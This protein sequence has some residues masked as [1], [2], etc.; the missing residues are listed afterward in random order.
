MLEKIVRGDLFVGICHHLRSKL[1]RPTTC[2][3]S[4]SSIT[5]QSSESVATSQSQKT[6]EDQEI[7]PLRPSDA[8]YEAQS[9]ADRIRLDEVIQKVAELGYT[10]RRLPQSAFRERDWTSMMRCKTDWCIKNHLGFVRARLKDG[11]SDRRLKE[12]KKSPAALEKKR[13]IAED[14]TEKFARGEMVYSLSKNN[15]LLRSTR[16]RMKREFYLRQASMMRL[17]ET[18]TALVDCGFLPLQSDKEVN[19][20]ASQIQHLLTDNLRSIEPWNIGLVNLDPQAPRMKEYI[21]MFLWPYM[22]GSA[23]ESEVEVDRSAVDPRIDPLISHKSYV[24]LFDRD[25]LVYLSPDAEEEL[26]TIDNDDIY[27][28]GAIVDVDW[29]NRPGVMKKKASWHKA[30]EDGVRCV[31]LPLDKYIKS[32]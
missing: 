2:H 5:S 13:L 1:I 20:T 21:N 26:E 31:K 12:A 18:P 29:Q 16:R 10:T 25:R 32:V 27:I 14:D 8:F 23:F 6:A 17:G 22:G 30:K 24:D 11:E 7:P 15:M 3:R 19:G 28:I 9:E 4:L